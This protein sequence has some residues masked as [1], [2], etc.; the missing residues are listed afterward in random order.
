MDCDAA[1]KGVEPQDFPN[2]PSARDAILLWT[3]ISVAMV[4]AM[5]NPNLTGIVL[6]Y[7]STD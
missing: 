1:D 3:S 2:L 7:Q 5:T 4:A 6:S